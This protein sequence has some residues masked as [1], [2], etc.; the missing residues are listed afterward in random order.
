MNIRKIAV[1][2][3]GVMGAGIA[4]HISNAGIPVYLLDIVPDSASNRNII[5][6]TAIQKM[7]KTEPAP[8]M[9]KNNARL[10]TAGNIEDHLHLLAEVDWVIEAVIEQLHTKK[11][12]YQK[13]ESVCH[14]DCIISSNT[15]TLP[16]HLLVQDSPESFQQRF[17]ISHF[18]NPPRYMRLLELVA[19]PQT[20]PELLAAV[21]E[22]AD[23]KLGKECVIC[24]DTPGFIANRI[25]IYWLQCGLVEAISMGISVE[26]A[27]AIMTAFGIPKT[28]IFGLL[29]LIGLDLIPHILDSMKHALSPHDGLHEFIHLPELVQTMITNGYT[30]RKG[31][32]GFYRLN[33]TNGLRVK[34][35][36]NLGTGDYS[37]SKNVK[38]DAIEQGLT[39]LLTQTDANT[40][41]AWRVFSKTLSYAASLIPEISDDI[42]SI[43]VAMREGY[44]WELGPFELMDKLGLKQFTE[45]LQ[46]ENQSLPPILN[47]Q[48]NFYKL[49]DRELKATD[50]N[51]RYHPIHRPEG[52]LV[53]SDIK[54][55]NT[56]ILGNS[57][58]SLWDIGNGVTC[59]EFHSK[60]N[61]LDM[62]IMDLINESI[63]KIQN[64]FT[65]LVIYN[66]GINF[67]VGANLK[68]LIQSIHNSDW[69]YVE[70]L[71]Q[72]GQQTY[73]ALKY[74]LFPVVGAPS[75]L[76]M[77]GG[78]EILL[79][80]DAIQAHAEL[81][82]GLVEVGVGLIPG[83][84]GCK[85]YLR[86]W[87]QLE[88]RPKGPMP[89]IVSAFETI[90]MAKVSKSAIEAKE[91]LFLANTDGISI[92]KSR[93]LAD[94]KDKALALANNYTPPKPF[95][96]TSPGATARIVL[97]MGIKAFH[98]LGKASKYDVEI[99]E[100][101][102]NVLSGGDDADITAPIT[103]EDILALE[104]TAFVDLTKQTS[105]LARLEHML[106]TG[107][108]LRN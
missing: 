72:K 19:S 21:S 3:A 43:D 39:S 15:S 6:E 93:L 31:K 14:K 88:T 86:R 34:E 24:K 90:A 42:S 57:S 41:Y 106:K 50:L 62:D 4:A 29:D 70:Q 10:I 105:T 60:M 16:L 48:E 54:R 22:F 12:L 36:I 108:A 17:M 46:A 69:E 23:V 99:A 47:R 33:T 79:H 63:D 95:I 98:F 56:L 51:G 30:G 61:T 97:D 45:K 92:N 91:M 103:E 18:F 68:L 81:Y 55:Q 102:A 32:G 82:M 27:D 74:A 96:Y 9:H 5:A 59:L 75:G 13:L 77:G 40:V 94:A 104:C 87:Q 44:H 11:S 78:C 8:F 49:E 67:S 80:C 26:Q 35:S 1:I 107:K 89:P 76:A 53:L 38:P 101:L 100:H 71:I 28:G 37:L 83:W 84:G 85:E 25:G 64:E 58:A 2:G 52:V 20:R 65:A 66:D 73:Q 7:L